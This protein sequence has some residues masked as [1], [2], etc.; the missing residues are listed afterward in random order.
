MGRSVSTEDLIE[1]N[2]IRAQANLPPIDQYGALAVVRPRGNQPDGTPDSGLLGE[3]NAQEVRIDGMALEAQWAGDSC[4]GES[5]RCSVPTKSYIGLCD[6][7]EE[8]AGSQTPEEGEVLEDEEGAYSP[9]DAEVSQSI[10]DQVDAMIAKKK[11]K[12]ARW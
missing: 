1:I 10:I 8:P 7:T 2:K 11:G 9:P 3:Q 4:M 6:G 12:L 5:T